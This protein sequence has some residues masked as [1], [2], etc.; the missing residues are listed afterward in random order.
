[1]LVAVP[2]GAFAHPSAGPATCARSGYDYSGYAS[3]G[4]VTAVAATISATVPPHVA[5]GHTAAW[6]G[7][8]D[9]GAHRWLQAGLASFRGTSMRLYYE[10]ALPGVPRRYVELDRAVVVGERYRV[11]VVE[12]APGLWQVEVDGRAAM[13]PVALPG[14][15]RGIAT[16]ESWT[17]G[18][19]PCNRY[20][21]RFRDVVGAGAPPQFVA[22]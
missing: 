20:G 21:Y 1:V 17:R 7:V 10:L 8:G 22:S 15:W 4:P 2:I 19:Q 11:A 3:R 6:V 12:R 5:S 9:R 18:A 14:T 13:T 16:A